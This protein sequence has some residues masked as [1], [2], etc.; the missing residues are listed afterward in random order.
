[1][2]LWRKQFALYTLF[3]ICTEFNKNGVCVPVKPQRMISS[4]LATRR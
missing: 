2:L 3:N 1:M 4:T